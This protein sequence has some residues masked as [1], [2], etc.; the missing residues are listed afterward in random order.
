[1]QKSRVGNSKNT[2]DSLLLSGFLNIQEASKLMESASRIKCER[3]ITL[4]D[5]FTLA[6]AK[7]KKL[8]ALFATRENELVK[9]MERK[10]FEV[11]IEFL[12]NE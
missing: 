10:T 12:K 2:V 6:L 9:E 11:E 5:C 7:E 4:S 1:M 3:P 8:K